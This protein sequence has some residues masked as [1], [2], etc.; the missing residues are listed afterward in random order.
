MA[1]ILAEFLAVKIGRIRMS[2]A[3][4]TRRKFVFRL[5]PKV[6]KDNPMIV[7]FLLVSSNDLRMQIEFNG[8]VISD[9]QYTNG[10]E[11]SIQE[12]ANHVSFTTADNDMIFTVLRGEAVFRDVILWFLDAI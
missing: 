12:F 4:D 9:R 8:T 1:E 11:R 10:P 7:T 2:V 5:P 3:A 6:S